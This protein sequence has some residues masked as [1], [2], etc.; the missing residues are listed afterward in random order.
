MTLYDTVR[1]LKYYRSVSIQVRINGLKPKKTK[2]IC[3][4]CQ[5]ALGDN[6]FRPWHDEKGLPPTPAALG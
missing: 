4:R 1:F 3:M 2:S 6:C 5:V